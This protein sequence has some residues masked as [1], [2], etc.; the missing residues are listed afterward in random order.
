MVLTLDTWLLM[1]AALQEKVLA[2]AA[3]LAQRD[4]DIR[5][6][7][8]RRIV[9]CSIED[10][11]A[12]LLT[13]DED[14]LLRALS[15]ARDGGFAGWVLPSIHRETEGKARQRKPFPFEL[16]DVLPWWKAVGEHQRASRFGPPVT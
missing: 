5:A 2:S 9:F 14:S 4:D 7:D 16:G 15:A 8:R 11:E 6:E 13:S 1:S 12:T 10:L 3:T